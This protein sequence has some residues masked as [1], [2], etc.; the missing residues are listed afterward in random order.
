MEL[1]RPMAK[2]DF[3]DAISID[4]N[5]SVFDVTPGFD[6]QDATGL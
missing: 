6:V 3:L 1:R 5:A 2:A 4:Q